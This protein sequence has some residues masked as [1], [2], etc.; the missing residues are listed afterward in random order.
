MAAAKGSPKAGKGSMKLAKGSPKGAYAV[1]SFAS[2]SGGPAIAHG[3][4]AT[5]G[6]PPGSPTGSP[7]ATP[8]TPATPM[9][10]VGMSLTGS[11]KGTGISKEEHELWNQCVRNVRDYLIADGCVFKVAITMGGTHGQIDTH[12]DGVL[13]DLRGKEAPL[14]PLFVDIPKKLT[15]FQI[16]AAPFTVPHYGEDAEFVHQAT[17]SKLEMGEFLRT[18][19]P[20]NVIAIANKMKLSDGVLPHFLSKTIPKDFSDSDGLVRHGLEQVASK[21]AIPISYTSYRNVNV[22]DATVCAYPPWNIGTRDKPVSASQCAVPLLNKTY[23][24]T[25]EEFRQGHKTQNEWK[26]VL[27]YLGKDG[28]IK[29]FN[30]LKHLID[31]APFARFPEW[32][33]TKQ[34]ELR[35]SANYTFI[36]TENIV[37]LVYA[38]GFKT[39]LHVDVTCNVIRDGHGGG[40]IEEQERTLRRDL[41]LVYIPNQLAIQAGTVSASGL[42]AMLRSLLLVPIAQG[43]GRRSSGKRR[44]GR[45]T[46]RRV[47]HHSRGRQCVRTRRRR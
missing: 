5:P 44:T 1:A 33:A 18:P 41:N 35:P 22:A 46:R 37:K 20:D 19:S 14:I 42:D 11:P 24:L 7:P 47:L 23:L 28:T 8:A 34:H 21:K 3:A 17:A 30:I 9:Y 32:T 25:G 36:T 27:Y 6:S 2:L 16:L 39:Q 13:H 40:V 4:P 15:M 10:P 29:K 31:K 12:Q 43:G 26:F 45:Q 38:V